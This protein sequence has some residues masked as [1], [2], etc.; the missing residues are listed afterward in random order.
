[1]SAMVMDVRTVGHRT[2]TDGMFDAVVG[3]THPRG[4]GFRVLS[5]MARVRAEDGA[6]YA[7]RHRGEAPVGF[8]VRASLAG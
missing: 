7:P 8:D 1:M 4:Q 3:R 2:E 6:D 5:R